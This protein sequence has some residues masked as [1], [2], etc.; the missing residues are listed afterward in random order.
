MQNPVDHLPMVPP[1]ATTVVTDGQERL[2]P[3][4]LGI[5]QIAPPHV[6]IN[7]A[8]ATQ[9][10]DRPDKSA[11]ETAAHQEKLKKYEERARCDQEAGRRGANGR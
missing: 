10:H 2:E 7:D 9:S 5:R 11:A 6:H 3:F 4:P 1:S 8:D